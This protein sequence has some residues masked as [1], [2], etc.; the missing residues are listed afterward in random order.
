MPELLLALVIGIP[1]FYVYKRCMSRGMV[2]IDHVGTF[3]FG[4]LF[5]WITPLAVRLWAAK[6]QFPL[7]S[8]WISLFREK[9]IVPY[10]VACLALYVSFAFGD[11]LGIKLFRSK[12]ARHAAKT[13]RLALS[14]VT[15]AG[16][17]LF[18]YTAF[19]FR[20]ELARQV[21]PTD[22]AAEAARGAVTTCVVLL[23]VV[24]IIFTLDRPE[25][26][27]GKRFRSIYFLTFFV[28]AVIMLALGSRLYVASFVVMF[29]VYLTNFRKRL[30]LTSVIASVLVLAAFFGAVG[31]W[32]EQGDFR[33]AF[34]NVLE[35]PM[36]N[37]LSLVHH[38][39][40]K[41]ISWVNSPDQLESDFLNLV[42]TVLLPNKFALLKKPDAYRPLGGLNSFVSFDLNFGMIG[43]GLFLFLWPILFRYLKSRSSSTLP[44][45]IY[46]MC[47]GWLAFTFFR[48]PFSISLV[49]AILQDSVILPAL[50]V[51]FGWLLTEAC[52]PGVAIA[53]ASLDPQL[54]ES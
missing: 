19:T 39:R 22:F 34:F 4:F 51:G 32:R 46:I 12:P 9:L 15:L 2:L 45:T 18:V 47:S 40:H 11:S 21:T 28:G 26:S 30:K 23:G 31:I 48:D 17:L 7:S 35:E 6:V 41:G 16:C 25:M 52:R 43:T 5:Y 8:T 42:P 33:G 50:I 13:P 3:T 49:K 54:G 10:A 24:C 20:A 14:F 37:S 38:L 29:A 53:N 44:A 1:C 36:L 27:W